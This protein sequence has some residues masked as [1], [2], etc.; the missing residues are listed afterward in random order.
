MRSGWYFWTVDRLYSGRLV[1]IGNEMSSPKMIDDLVRAATYGF[2]ASAGRDLYRGIRNRPFLIVLLIVVLIPWSVRSFFTGRHRAP[3]ARLFMNIVLPVLGLAAGS[4]ALF[5]LC[6]I[7]FDS[8]AAAAGYTG[9]LLAIIGLLALA[10]SV[11]GLLAGGRQRRALADEAHNRAFLEKIG[12]KDAGLDEGLLIDSEGN[13]LR[14]KERLSDRV[15]LTVSGKRGKRAVIGVENGKFT[16]Y[17]G[18]VQ[19]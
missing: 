19:A 1:Q 8:S 5:S 18:I 6:A 13:L 14:I 3:L 4:L 11:W 16:S 12:L 2:G 15:V 9:P 17:S 10:G 7:F